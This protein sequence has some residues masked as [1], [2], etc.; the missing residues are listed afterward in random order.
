MSKKT[1]KFSVHDVPIQEK[2]K[3]EILCDHI[4]NSNFEEIRNNVEIYKPFINNVIS[5]SQGFNLFNYDTKYLSHHFIGPL[6][7]LEVKTTPLMLACQKENYDIINLLLDN[8]ADVNL[9][10]GGQTAL[11]IAF[12]Y[13]TNEDVICKLIRTANK[14]TLSIHNKC[15]HYVYGGYKYIYLDG[16]FH[17]CPTGEYSDV[18]IIKSCIN[19]KYG[20]V[21][22]A[23]IE[24]PSCSSTIITE[25]FEK[26][27]YCG[28]NYFDKILKIIANFH[29]K[30]IG[31]NIERNY[32]ILIKSIIHCNENI[33]LAIIKKYPKEAKPEHVKYNEIF[34][35]TN[36]V[37]NPFSHA[38]TQSY[39]ALVAAC[40]KGYKTLAQELLKLDLPNSDNLLEAVI[41]ACENNMVD[42]ANTIVNLQNFKPKVIPIIG[43][44]IKIDNDE[45]LNIII[46][47]LEIDSEYLLIE[48]TENIYAVIKKIINSAD[49]DN[50]SSKVDINYEN[51]KIFDALKET[52]LSCLL[53][54]DDLI[55]DQ[56]VNTS[57]KD[58]QRVLIKSL[59]E[60]TSDNKNKE[61]LKIFEAC[62]N[63][64]CSICYEKCEDLFKFSNCLHVFYLDSKCVKSF[65]SCPLC[66]TNGNPEKCYLYC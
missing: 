25:M 59:L 34:H 56:I 36:E 41:S 66:K 10:L 53:N 19:F 31:R 12:L 39:S 23:I 47:L 18:S 58:L 61:I 33:P 22:D 28:N 32:T 64:E 37:Y 54:K 65:K 26:L 1:T 63:K 11:N 2:T 42:I 21:L 14:N 3:I 51:K 62:K 24:S 55:C 57:D 29:L 16:E 48:S 17:V 7:W 5:L 27:I 9:I 40:E 6:T 35:W 46:K 38:A 50:F 8:G 43:R 4:L 52:E 15:Y 45:V 60:N 20:K 30:D 44:L 49:F 13:L